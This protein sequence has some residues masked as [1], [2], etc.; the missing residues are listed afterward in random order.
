VKDESARK[1]YPKA[2]IKKIILKSMLASTAY[3]FH[4]KL[5]FINCL[6]KFSKRTSLGFYRRY[7]LFTYSGRVVFRRFKI[8]RHVF[9]HFASSGYLVGFRK[10]SF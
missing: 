3:P 2:E 10:S 1:R 9:K 8:S 5:Y 6:Q 7:C 4:Y